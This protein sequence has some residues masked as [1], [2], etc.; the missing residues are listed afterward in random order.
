MSFK[1][2]RKT[3]EKA[4]LNFY[5][6]LDFQEFEEAFEFFKPDPRFSLDQYLLQK[7]VQDGGLLPSYAKLDSISTRTLAQSKNKKEIE[8]Y[9]R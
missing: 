5:N 8:V 6:R 2:E 7:S 3:G 9:T 4:V 1:N